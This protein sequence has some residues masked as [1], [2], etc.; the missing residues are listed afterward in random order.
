MF[1]DTIEWKGKLERDKVFAT[2]M[3]HKGYKFR[4]YE[5]LLQSNKEREKNKKKKGAKEL[6]G[7]S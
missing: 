1:N 3:A 6:R 5:E 4:I 2:H 7:T